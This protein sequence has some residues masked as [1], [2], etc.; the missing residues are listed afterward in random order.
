MK[1]RNLFSCIAAGLCL[2]ITFGCAPFNTDPNTT[3]IHVTGPTGAPFAATYWRGKE[4]IH[5]TGTL[6][7]DFEGTNLSR[8]EFQKGNAADVYT[9]EAHYSDG[10]C[11]TMINKTL[12]AG[13]SG[14]QIAVRH[15]LTMNV[16]SK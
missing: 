9:I 5:V 2:F 13:T 10:K 1:T 4:P 16:I 7:W 15:G 3:T 12:I 6:P 8:I 11:Q 14:A